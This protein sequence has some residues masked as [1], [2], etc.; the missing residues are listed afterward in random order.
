MEYIGTYILNPTTNEQYRVPWNNVYKDLY[1]SDPDAR[2]AGINQIIGYGVNCK[3]FVEDLVKLTKDDNII[4]RLRAA[5]ALE[6]LTL[7]HFIDDPIYSS[8]AIWWNDTGKRNDEYKSKKDFSDK[9]I[10]ILKQGSLD[11]GPSPIV[12]TFDKLTG[13][14]MTRAIMADIYM[15]RSDSKRAKDQ[16][17][18][19]ENECDGQVEPMMEYA[20]LLVKEGKLQLATNVL[21]RI[22]PYTSDFIKELQTH[23]LLDALKNEQ[24]FKALINSDLK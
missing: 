19:I 2:Q 24:Q 9:V 7:K 14:C 15:Q 20:E 22:K 23:H 3:C 5:K 6:I 13:F 10:S 16:W 21:T 17:I 8:V 4:V 12:K 1:N 18:R 11:V